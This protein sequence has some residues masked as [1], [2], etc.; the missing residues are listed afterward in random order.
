MSILFETISFLL[1]E[2]RKEDAFKKYPQ[3]SNEIEFFIQNDPS[4]NLKYLNWELEQ[5]QN[6]LSSKEEIVQTVNDFNKFQSSLTNKDISKYD[7][8]TLKNK[9][10]TV[11]TK[12]SKKKEKVEKLYRLE[13]KPDNDVIYESDTW[14][15]IHLKNKE[16]AC[17]FGLNTKW[18]ISQKEADYF[19]DYTKKD[20]IMYVLLNKLDKEKYACSIQRDSNKILGVEWWN[21]ADKKI[22][23]NIQNILDDEYT[24]IYNELNKHAS[25]EEIYSSKFQKLSLKEQLEEVKIDG[26]TI[27]YIENP[28]ELFQFEAIKQNPRSLKYIENPTERVQ[29]MVVKQIG[30]A[31]QYIKNPTEIVQFEAVKRDGWA[32]KFIENPSEDVQLEA[33]KQFVHAI[34]YIKN[35]TQK[36]KEL[37][38]N[39]YNE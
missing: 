36:V 22:N 23:D 26:L 17:H 20:V 29:L 1:I 37:H 7:I 9:L 24:I 28:S 4:K 3:F 30:W 6:G 38:K 12:Q 14:K 21:S 33:V 15:V 10:E 13:N 27:R 32:I 31:I 35:P 34:E 19:N 2:G 5:L 39:L 16:A 25:M 18:C 8:E 11:K